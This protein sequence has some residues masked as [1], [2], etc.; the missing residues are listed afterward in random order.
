MKTRNNFLFIFLF[1]GYAFLYIP[2]VTVI[3]F[4][5]NES[6]IVTSW[7]GLSVKW[8]IKLFQNESIMHAAWLSLKIAFITALIAIIIG[9]LAAI[10]MV[11]FRTFKGRK[12]F[13]SIVTAPLL[14]PDVIVGFALLMF[15]ISTYQIFGWPANNGFTTI[16][17]GHVTM[18]I[19]Y[20]ILIV[21]SR[22]LEIDL[23]LEEA[24]LDLGARP[25]KVFLKI[26]L[27]IIMP[28]IASGG[29]LAFTLSFDDVILASFLSGPG[30]STLPMVI[31][32]SIRY[33]VTPEIN[34]LS[35]I[36]LTIVAI[37]VT[38]AGVFIH[39]RQYDKRGTQ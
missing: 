31:F 35:T 6:K 1:F 28:S 7:S 29:L 30:Y 27:P 37:G 14:M 16:V 20:V 9:T 33:G 38:I 34:A 23:S 8:Y 25:A 18:A 13:N 21:R 12:F 32:S 36:F 19:A 10:V 15:F 17:I 39:K 26:T 4:S 22:L 24:A 11:R 5:F 3:L 2:I